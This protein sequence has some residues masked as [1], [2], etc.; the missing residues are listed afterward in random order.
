MRNDEGHFNNKNH[1]SQSNNR[2]SGGIWGNT[3]DAEDKSKEKKKS[4]SW[5]N[6]K[7]ERSNSWDNDDKKAKKENNEKIEKKG[8]V[9]NVKNMTDDRDSEER[10]GNGDWDR[11]EGNR[12]E[13]SRGRDVGRD[14]NG[15]QRSP[16]RSISPSKLKR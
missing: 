16:N 7:T 13:R 10:R 12:E 3:K 6:E 1:D 8:S 14:E 5:D 9:V 2:N 4:A 11:E 15:N